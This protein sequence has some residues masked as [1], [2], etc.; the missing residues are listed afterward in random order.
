MSYQC[1]LSNLKV[2]ERWVLW[3]VVSEWTRQL[4]TES[5]TSYPA[6]STILLLILIALYYCYFTE[7][8]IYYY[9]KFSPL[10]T[11]YPPIAPLLFIAPLITQIPLSEDL[12]QE[13]LLY[14][15]KRLLL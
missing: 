4:R 7:L 10:K 6:T 1:A 9:F 15:L 3:R 12:P 2:L 8:L 11:N 13:I 14:N 5:D